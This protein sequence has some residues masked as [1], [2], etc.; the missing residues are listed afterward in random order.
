MEEGIIAAGLT[1]KYKIEIA[2]HVISI[3]IINTTSLFI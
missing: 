1:R 2:I 3:A